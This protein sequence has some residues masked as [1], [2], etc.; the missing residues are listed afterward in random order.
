MIFDLLF[1][2]IDWLIGL[3]FSVIP[4]ISVLEGGLLDKVNDFITLVVENGLTLFTFI[5]R[6]STVAFAIPLM[7]AIIF[8][9]EIY[10]I[11]MFILKKIPFLNIK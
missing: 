3:I 8:G 11:V 7:I 9:G 10:H 5:I 6:P 1:T 4:S 2:C